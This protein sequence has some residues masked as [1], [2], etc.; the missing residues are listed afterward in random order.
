MK[1]KIAGKNQILD[2]TI[3]HLNLFYVCFFFTKQIERPSLVV[4]VYQVL[5]FRFVLYKIA[6]FCG[7]RKLMYSHGI[8]FFLF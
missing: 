1:N 5:V 3:A 2:R 4:N 7:E 6:H 8:F